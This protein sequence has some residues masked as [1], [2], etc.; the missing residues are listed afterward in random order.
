VKS[1]LLGTRHPRKEKE[2]VLQFLCPVQQAKLLRFKLPLIELFLTSPF[3]AKSR[4]TCR[5]LTPHEL[6]VLTKKRKIEL[7]A[8]TLGPGSTK[9]MN[10]DDTRGYYLKFTNTQKIK[11]VTSLEDGGSPLIEIR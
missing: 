1:T 3:T 10:P 2:A 7:P 5:Q 6:G 4:R 8:F 9:C 11:F